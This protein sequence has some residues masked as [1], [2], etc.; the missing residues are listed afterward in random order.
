MSTP[1]PIQPSPAPPHRKANLNFIFLTLL[2]DVL[3]FSLLIP[4][5]PKLVAEVQGLPIRGSESETSLEYG[6]LVATY[7]AMQF[8]FAPVLGSLSDRF[9]RRPVILISLLGSGL[10]YIAAALAPNLAV[11]FITRAINGLSGANITACSA[12]IADVTPPERRAAG[13]GI[14]GA[15]FGIGFVIGPLA[16]SYLAEFGLRVPFMVAAGLTLANWLYGLLVLPESLPKEHRR[17]FSWRR[18]NAFGSLAWLGTHRLVATLAASVFLLNISQFA[19]HAT[20][21]LAMGLRFQWSNTDVGWSLFI[22]GLSAAIVQGGLAR[23]IIP[24]LGERACLLGGLVIGVFAYIG[25]GA[26]THGWMMYAI[27]AAASI[28]AVAGPAMQG[29]MSKSIPPTEQGMLQGSLASLACVSQVL[30]YLMGTGVFRL[31]THHDAAAKVPGANF[32]ASAAVCALALVPVLVAW[33]RLPRTVREPGD[34]TIR[35][36]AR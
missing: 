7:A 12:Y 23:R 32:Y 30:G 13:F 15:A 31:F 18:A 17:P 11:L 24:A 9:G 14:V 34:E 22:V 6:L 27:I 26:A 33:K 10:D 29:V 8:F 2:L 36:P 20:W 5:A 4:V 21:V 3:G 1:T 35:I 25:Y 16:G 19:L 28:G